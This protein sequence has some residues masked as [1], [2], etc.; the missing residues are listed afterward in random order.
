MSEERELIADLL[1]EIDELHRDLHYLRLEN[2]KLKAKLRKSNEP[3]NRR[4]RLNH[5]QGSNSRQ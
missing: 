4:R 1:K 5:I 2:K 3:N